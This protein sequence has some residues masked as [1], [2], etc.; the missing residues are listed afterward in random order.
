MEQ[1]EEEIPIEIEEEIK[2]AGLLN[3]GENGIRSEREDDGA[4]DD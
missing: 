3:E 2:A 1:K 4:N